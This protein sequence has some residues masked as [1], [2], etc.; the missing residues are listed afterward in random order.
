MESAYERLL[1][2][3]L[4]RRGLKV[5][6]QRSVTF[7]YDGLILKNA[8]K[9]DMLVNDSV[10]VEIKAAEKIHPMYRRQAFTYLRVLGLHVA[11]LLNFGAPTMKQG[12]RRIVNDYQPTVLSKLRIDASAGPAESHRSR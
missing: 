4:Q 10:V 11:L 9:V 1:S 8:F 12:I 5:D 7:E 6:R 2:K 3:E